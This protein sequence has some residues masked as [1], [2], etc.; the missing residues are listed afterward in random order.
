MS[1]GLCSSSAKDSTVEVKIKVANQVKSELDDMFTKME[2]EKT[3]EEAR[4]LLVHFLA[5][6]LLTTNLMEF[7]STAIAWMIDREIA[8]QLSP[9]YEERVEKGQ[10]VFFCSVT[11]SSSPRAPEPV[12]GGILADDMGLG[13]TLSALVLIAAKKCVGPARKGTLIICPLSVISNW[14]DQIK[15]HF[16]HGTLSCLIHHG[17]AR[18]NGALQNFDVVISSCVSAA[19]LL[20][21]LSPRFLQVSNRRERIR[22]AERQEGNFSFQC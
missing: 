9:F 19:A 12:C 15:T 4:Q 21:H 14:S 18:D 7:Q 5:T 22:R 8:R 17:S 2:T 16:Q 13:K 1:G 6:G 10:R 20:L 3:S 11:N